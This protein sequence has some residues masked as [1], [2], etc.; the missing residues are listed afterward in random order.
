[1]QVRTSASWDRVMLIDVPG[2]RFPRGS[3][4]TEILRHLP[5]GHT[6]FNLAWHGSGDARPTA[7]EGA[8]GHA[9]CVRKVGQDWYL[10]DSEHDGP[11]RLTALGWSKLRGSIRL[12]A[13]YDS[14]DA[15][16]HITGKIVRGVPTT[17]RW[18]TPA[19]VCRVPQCPAASARGSWQETQPASQCQA[20]TSTQRQQDSAHV[21]VLEVPPLLTEQPRQP[22]PRPPTRVSPPNAA[23]GPRPA[24]RQHPEHRSRHQKSTR[25][26]WT[27]PCARRA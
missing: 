3:M 4:E 5:Q 21:E 10:L 8:Y 22:S 19:Q 6:S 26:S 27:T 20:N 16:G 14:R 24:R 18:V 2:S 23:K 9:V 15:A 25:D 11:E 17:P 12:L 13:A 7:N 1:M